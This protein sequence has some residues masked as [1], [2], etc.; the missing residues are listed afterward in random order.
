MPSTDSTEVAA[1]AVDGV[2][3]VGIFCLQAHAM[4]MVQA[5]HVAVAAAVFSHS[6]IKAGVHSADAL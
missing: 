5:S 2:G 4:V 1:L 3:S 6:L